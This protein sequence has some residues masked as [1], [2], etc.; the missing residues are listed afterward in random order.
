MLKPTFIIAM[1]ATLAFLAVVFGAFGAHALKSKLSSEYLLVYQTG[2]DYQFYH[3][4]AL[5]IVGV[6]AKLFP[7][8]TSLW[9]SALLFILGILLFSGSLYGLAISGQKW[10]GPITPIGGL[11]FLA[12]W[13]YLAWIFFASAPK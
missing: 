7:E 2:V 8:M 4:L 11:A 12:G 10:L 5:I 9:I 13:V 6:L 3:A 1:G